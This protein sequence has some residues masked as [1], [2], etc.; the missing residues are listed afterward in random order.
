MVALLGIAYLRR[1][2]QPLA[3]RG[4][5]AVSLATLIVSAVVHA[6][7]QRDA[8]A[9]RYAVQRPAAMMDRQAW[10]QRDWQSL[11]AWRI[12]IEG[13]YE[14]PLTVQ[15]AGQL[16]FLR[17]RLESKGWQPAV[18]LSGSRLLLWLDPRRTAMQ[19]PLLP[20]V[21]DGRYETLAMFH[22]VADAP[23]KRLVLRLW[24][25][26]VEL[27]SPRLP[28]WIGTVALETI[29]RPMSWI[30]L[31]RDSEDFN[32]PR[33]ILRQSLDDLPMRQ[34]ARSAP[35]E[36]DKEDVEWDKNVLLIHQPEPIH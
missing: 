35:P 3:A 19:L 2:A 17:A 9:I 22:P 18:P 11:S 16:P 32:T 26:E 36:P 7:Y 1:Q 24:P 27:R 12:D 14:Q 5:L 29:A 15:W 34:V 25:T 13:E 33:Q 28:I 6:A 31:P 21:H 23:D 4:L 30:N 20:H 8:D 10:W